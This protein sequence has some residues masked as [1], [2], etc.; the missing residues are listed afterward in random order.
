M[1]LTDFW[2]R[3]DEVHGL[4]YSQSWAR[5]VVLSPLGCTAVEAIERGIDTKEIWRAVC[6]VVEVPPRLR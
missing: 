3:M 4:G 5:D 1:R 2:E 6:T